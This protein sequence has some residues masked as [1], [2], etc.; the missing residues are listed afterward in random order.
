MRITRWVWASGLLAALSML[1]SEAPAP[2]LQAARVQ[3]DDLAFSGPFRGVPAGETRYLSR[4][5]LLRLAGVKKLRAKLTPSLPEAELTVLPIPALLEAMPIGGDADGLLLTCEDRWQSV[6]PLAFVRSHAPY[7]L[8]LYEGR[9]PAEGWPKF[10]NVEAFAPYYVDVDHALHPGFDGIIDEGMISATQVIEFR[11]MNVGRHYAPFRAG[12]L[13]QLGPQ[14]DAGRKLF[15]RACNNCHQGPGG[16]GG[17][18]SQRPLA[19]L[20][21]HATTNA[22]Y[23]RKLVRKPKDFFPNTVMPPHPHFGEEQFSA[24]IAF[25]R[26][27]GAAAAAA[28]PAGKA[29]P[30]VAEGFSMELLRIPFDHQGPQ[31]LDLAVKLSYFAG[32]TQQDYP[33][34]E[35]IHREILAFLAAYPKNT[36]YVETVNRKLCLDLLQR[37]PAITTVAIDMRSHPTMTIPYFHTAHAAA[38]R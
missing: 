19:V 13:A 30:K 37:H 29:E 9:T 6:L 18:T 25:L 5:A 32:I 22:D 33:D 26:E 14:A 16:V 4:A 28:A 20:Q 31:L 7:L 17:N 11:A 36:D 38:S 8:L 35:V 34:F 3:P 10:S 21:A 2:V 12:A 27:S 1:A 23:F 24:L 15:I